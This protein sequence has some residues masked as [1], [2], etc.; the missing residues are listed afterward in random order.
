M[1]GRVSDMSKFGKTQLTASAPMHDQRLRIFISYSHEDVERVKLIARVIEKNGMEAIY[2]DKSGLHVGTGFKDEIIHFITHA[3]IFLPLLTEASLKRPW[4]QQEIG[5]AVAS[6]VPTVP[7]AI[8]CVP[9]EFLHGIQAIQL[10]TLETA[11]LRERLTEK[12][13]RICLQKSPVRGSLYECA[14]TTDERAI[15]LAEYARAVTLTGGTGLVRQSGGLS[16]FHIPDENIDH[17]FWQLRYGKQHQ[18]QFHRKVLLEERLALTEHAKK[19]GCRI[20]IDPDLGYEFYGE[21]ARRTRLETL[22][23]FLHTMKSVRCEVA[24]AS[25]AMSESVT[26]VGDWFAAHS[27]SGRMGDGY[28]QTIF[29]RHAPTIATMIEEFDRR[30]N[31]YLYGAPASKSRKRA[32]SEIERRIAKLPATSSKKTGKRS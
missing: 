29:T 4:V 31:Q 10:K 9:G 8:N 26:I 12:A 15:L 32:I 18:S 7:V 2:D 16:S 22:L 11:K 17:P 1:K 14:D 5:Y 20:I 23:R 24:M 13:L 27:I 30:F 6:R 3:H 28:R 25:I 21:D 19:K